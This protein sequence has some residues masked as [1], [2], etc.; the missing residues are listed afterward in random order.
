MDLIFFAYAE[1]PRYQHQLKIYFPETSVHLPFLCCI[2]EGV[3]RTKAWD[4]G[5]SCSCFGLR[6][7]PRWKSWN[8][9]LFLGT[10][11]TKMTLEKQLI[12]DVYLLLKYVDVPTITNHVSLLEGKSCYVIFWM[13]RM[14][15]WRSEAKPT[16]SDFDPPIVSMT[17]SII[18]K[19]LINVAEPMSWS[20]LNRPY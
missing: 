4:P 2:P 16:K 10:P 3:Y 20:L 19:N 9:G 11:K 6:D 12:E 14:D 8:F 17:S 5:Y 18:I 7:D 15:K 1:L 13:T